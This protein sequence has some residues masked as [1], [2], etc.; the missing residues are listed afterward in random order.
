MQPTEA[1]RYGAA[2]LGPIAS[3][4][5]VAGFVGNQTFR[6]RA[7]SGAVAYLKTG[8]A[9]AAEAHAI[10][11]ARELGVPAPRILA[12]DLTVP[13]LLTA[14]LPGA[15]SEAPA[16]VRAAA[17]CLR[18]LHT[19]HADADWAATLLEPVQ[20][21]DELVPSDLADQLRR[22]LPPFIAEVSEVPPVLLHGDLHVRHLYAESGRLSGIL[23]WGDSMYGDPLFDVARFTMTADADVVLA[24]YGLSANRELDRIFSQY[25]ILWSLMALRAEIAAG[26][27]WIDPHV[28]RIA[29]ELS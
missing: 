11:A 26:G 27:D 5:P 21:L 18:Q 2:V 25:R 23:D 19:V 4:E 1:S 22:V 8:A 10:G 29:A 15:P 12:T 9:I 6:L 17:S 3:T 14:E 28:R 24:G 7:A 20:V 16:V 13:Y